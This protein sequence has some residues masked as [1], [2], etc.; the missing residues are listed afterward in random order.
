MSTLHT[1][2]VEIRLATVEDADVIARTH[3]ASW[4]ATYPGIVPQVYLDSLS[5]EERAERWR[6]A[7]I[8]STGMKIY[9]AECSEMICGFASGGPA[10]AEITGF[11]GELY[12]IYL[13]PDVQ[14]RGIGSQLFWAIVEDLHSS[15][16]RGMYVWVLK[17][18]PSRGFYERMGGSLLTAAEIEIG[19]KTLTEVSY[20]WQDLSLVVK[21]L[22]QC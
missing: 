10:R 2:P 14:R 16:H 20:G 4:R 6:S 5:V 19:G 17:D 9:V 8:A 18:N 13:N 7:L 11:S 3:V 1:I 21:D 12:A 15:G 22:P